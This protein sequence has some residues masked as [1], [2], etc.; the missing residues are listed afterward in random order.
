MFAN[1]NGNRFYGLKISKYSGM[2]AE[3][4]VLEIYRVS[5]KYFPD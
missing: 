3:L 1:R 4:L 5:I 2:A